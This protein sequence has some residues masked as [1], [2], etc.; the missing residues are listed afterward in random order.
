MYKVLRKNP[1]GV[2]TSPR[3]SH[4]KWLPDVWHYPL[5]YSQGLYV[6][7]RLSL[8]HLLYAGC[9]PLQDMVVYQVEV[10][11]PRSAA[12]TVGGLFS[13]SGVLLQGLVTANLE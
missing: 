13:C 10:H 7:S 11:Q 5:D 1:N 6:F 2:L 9:E 12:S 3:F 8:R 4:Y